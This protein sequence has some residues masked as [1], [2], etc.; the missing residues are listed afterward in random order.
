MSNTLRVI[1]AVAFIAT[2]WSIT[3]Y[4]YFDSRSVITIEETLISPDGEYTAIL[5]SDMN[6][7]TGNCLRSRIAINP[8][9]ITFTPSGEDRLKRFRVYQG[10]CDV[11]PKI[12]WLSS[13]SIQI[14]LHGFVKPN[15]HRSP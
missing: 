5:Y 12:E 2:I 14:V 10:R 11:S 15:G 1:C 6:G 3:A 7:S 13:K 4:H 8:K 9:N